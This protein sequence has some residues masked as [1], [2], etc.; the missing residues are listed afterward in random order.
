M[1]RQLRELAR[2]GPAEPGPLRQLPD[3]TVDEEFGNVMMSMDYREGGGAG[4]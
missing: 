1:A 4:K 3:D 2:G